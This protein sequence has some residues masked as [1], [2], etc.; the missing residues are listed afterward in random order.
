M[1][2]HVMPPESRITCHKGELDSKYSKWL[3]PPTRNAESQQ[4]YLIFIHGNAIPLVSLSVKLHQGLQHTYY[5]LIDSIKEAFSSFQPQRALTAENPLTAG[6]IHYYPS[7]QSRKASAAENP[8]TAGDIHSYLSFQ[9]QRVSTVEN[10]LTVGEI[11]YY[12]SSQPQRAL[13]AENPFTAGDIHSYL[14]FQ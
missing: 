8:L 4:Y 3:D 2:C 9:Q 7:S 1:Y 6:D 13:A 5:E 14:S 12:P 11:H 10:P